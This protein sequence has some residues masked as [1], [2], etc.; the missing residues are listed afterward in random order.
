M[1]TCYFRAVIRVYVHVSDSINKKQIIV[2]Y[3]HALHVQVSQLLHTYATCCLIRMQHKIRRSTFAHSHLKL[4]PSVPIEIPSLTPIVLNRNP[5]IPAAC[6]PVFTCS[7]SCMRCMLH[8]LPS[9]QTDEMPTCGRGMGG[10]SIS[11]VPC[12]GGEKEVRI[13]V[14]ARVNGGDSSR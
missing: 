8:G 4:I 6:T 1:H 9:Y 13:D 2:V 5:T 3:T 11:T 10:W 14:F 12:L 7:A